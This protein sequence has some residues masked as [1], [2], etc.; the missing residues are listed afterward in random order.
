MKTHTLAMTMI[1]TAVTSMG[2]LTLA[3]GLPSSGNAGTTGG[4][5]NSSGQATGSSSGRTTG[6]PSSNTT[7]AGSSSGNINTNTGN[8]NTQTP[9]TGNTTP[10]NTT[11]GAGTTIENTRPNDLPLQNSDVNMRTETINPSAKLQFGSVES[12]DSKNN[13]VRV[14]DAQGNITNVRVGDSTT[15]GK[16]DNKRGTLKSIK[17]GDT[18]NYSVG[19][20]GTADRINFDAGTAK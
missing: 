11:T 12:V 1:L 7:G 19:A 14:R 9:G 5:T 16:R 10:L 8:I 18:I 4:S 17:A 6:S 15:Y 3:A 13:T 20:T 2:S